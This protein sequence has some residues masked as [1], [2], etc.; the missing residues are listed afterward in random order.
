MIRF[1]GYVCGNLCNFWVVF[2][3]GIYHDVGFLKWI[4][5]SSCDF[6]KSFM[7]TKSQITV[8]IEDMNAILYH[9]TRKSVIWVQG[10]VSGH[11]CNFWALLH[12]SI[13]H[14]ANFLKW[15]HMIL[16]ELSTYFISTKSHITVLREDVNAILYHQ[17]GK[18]VI[19][20]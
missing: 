1:W 13:Y 20:V 6:S 5:M 19:L 8:L 7:T 9:Q 17:T 15:L 18:P 12:L 14:G 4:R 16:Y 10:Y 2:Q 11:F 3:L